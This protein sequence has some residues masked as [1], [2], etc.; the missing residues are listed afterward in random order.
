MAY[1][2]IIKNVSMI[3][4]TGEPARKADVG[5][6]GKEIN[7]V[8]NVREAE[9]GLVI[10]GAGLY[11]M[12]GMIDVTNHAD[13]NFSLF[14][15]PEAENLVR[16]GITT[17]VTGVCGISLAPLTSPEDINVVSPWIDI[18]SVNTDWLSFAEFRETLRRQKLGVN[19]MTLV[20]YATIASH[21]TESSRG[22][23]E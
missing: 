4:G 9:G 16:Q 18:N 21:E 14:H 2:Y 5:I 7:A 19:V 1:S 13:R 15:A 8:G 6:S 11:C 12:P 23:A 10:D 20:G 3:D 22:D 17:I